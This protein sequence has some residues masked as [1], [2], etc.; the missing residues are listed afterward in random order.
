[1]DA[2]LMS[3]ADLVVLMMAFFIVLYAASRLDAKKAEQIRESLAKALNAHRATDA[4]SAQ[5]AAEALRIHRATE[6]TTGSQMA[7]YAKLTREIQAQINDQGLRYLASVRQVSTGVV[8]IATGDLLFASG[9][10]ELAPRALFLLGR[11][12]ELVVR[13]PYA[14]RIE[15]HTDDIPVHTLQFP[16]NWELSSARA[17]RVARFLIEYA[18]APHR[19]SVTGY[20]DTRP[21]P[22]TSGTSEAHQRAASRRVVILFDGSK[23]DP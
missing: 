21:F 20:A 14:I 8:L 22:T 3:F 16:S 17:S 10:A 9:S 2:W 12:A 23:M 5:R 19:I 13:L 18:I 6:V 7:D 15:G 1:M 11:I 4:W